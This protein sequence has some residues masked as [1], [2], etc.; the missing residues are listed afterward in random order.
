MWNSMISSIHSD[1][2]QAWSMEEMHENYF[3][4]NLRLKLMI[5]KC[6]WMIENNKGFEKK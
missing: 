6:G 2:S 5:D 1:N 4:L 3:N